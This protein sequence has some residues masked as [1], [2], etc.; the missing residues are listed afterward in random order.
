MEQPRFADDSLH[1][2]D[3]PVATLER[4]TNAHCGTILGL[5]RKRENHIAGIDG[6]IP[7]YLQ[8]ARPNR[9]PVVGLSGHHLKR[10]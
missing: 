10:R 9:V 6:K 1:V 7:V 8:L 3:R 5:L 4:R 2:R